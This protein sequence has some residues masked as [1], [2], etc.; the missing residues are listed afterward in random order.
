CDNLAVAHFG[1][2][3]SGRGIPAPR[4]YTMIGAVPTRLWRLIGGRNGP[5]PNGRHPDGSGRRDKGQMT[6]EHR[7][8]HHGHPA[9]YF[10]RKQVKSATFSVGT[11][12][13]ASQLA[14]GSLLAYFCRKHVKSATFRTGALVLASQLA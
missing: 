2:L 1:L 12:V 9:A 10:W 13:L 5:N 11:L 8:H 4:T 6:V 3:G 14:Y 7:V